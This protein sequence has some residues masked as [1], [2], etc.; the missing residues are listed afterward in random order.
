MLDTIME[1]HKDLKKGQTVKIVTTVK[2][3]ETFINRTDSLEEKDNVLIIHKSNGAKVA[4][5]TSCIAMCCVIE[6][7]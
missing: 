4:I 7:W 1:F 6:K 5:N 2:D 3:W